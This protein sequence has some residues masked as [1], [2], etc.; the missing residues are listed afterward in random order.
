VVTGAYTAGESVQQYRQNTLLERLD[1][2]GVT[3]TPHHRVRAVRENAV[4]LENLFSERTER[5]TGVDTVAFA[6]GGEA[7]YGLFREL[8]TAGHDVER[9][10][11]C[12]AP[13]SLDE[14]VWE[15]FEAAV[16][17]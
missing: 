7:D 5:R 10:G 9:V 3:L 14:A 15:G 17:L 1:E 11:D 2:R 4:V 8:D 13:R 16:E 12:W 6:H